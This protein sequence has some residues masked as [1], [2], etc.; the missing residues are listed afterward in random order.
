MS[1]KEEAAPTGTIK[2]IE[3]H[4]VRLSKGPVWSPKIHTHTHTHTHTH[5]L[6]HFFFKERER[7]R[8]GKIHTEILT[9]GFL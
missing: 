8:N 1:G 7:E 2:T 6:T 3:G 4:M 5:S 9:V